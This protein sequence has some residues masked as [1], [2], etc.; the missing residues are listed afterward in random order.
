MA[1]KQ[2]DE[3]K[4]SMLQ[5]VLYA[6]M[7]GACYADW[8][9]IW[10]VVQGV[11][12]ADR[13]PYVYAPFDK[14]VCPASQSNLPV[15]L[16]CSLVRYS[17]KHRFCTSKRPAMAAISGNLKYLP[18]NCD[19]DGTSEILRILN[20]PSRQAGCKTFPCILIIRAHNLKHGCAG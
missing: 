17:C 11:N 6:W 15:F 5:C 18:T 14:S 13:L 19:G 9:V 2:K 4:N 8:C 1:R 12:G 3:F 20:Y 16:R 10:D 7:K